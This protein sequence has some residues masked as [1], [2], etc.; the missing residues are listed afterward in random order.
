[1][2][3]KLTQCED[4]QQWDRFVDS[5]PQGNV[6]CSTPFLDALGEEYDLLLVEKDGHSQLG[7]VVLKRDGQPIPAP[8]SF[9]MYQGI[10]FDGSIRTMP[11][12][13][14]A[15]W[16]LE[17][18][19]FLLAEMEQRYNRISFCLH[20]ALEDLRSFQ[21]FHY[22]EPQR[23]QF[24]IELRYTGLVDLSGV[25]DFDTYLTAIRNLRRREYRRAQSKGLTVEESNDLDTLDRLH[26]LTFERQGID[27]NPKEERLLRA[28]SEAALSKSFGWLLLCK[29]KQGIAASATLFLY[30]SHCGYYL[31]G[32][33]DPDYRNSGSGTLLILENIRRCR[34]KGLKMVDFVGINS[35]NRG[36]FKTSFNA[37]PVPYFVVT[38]ERPSSGE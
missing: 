7:A 32:A 9:A 30:D 2:A 18:T 36:D 6:F 25:P 15:K 20:Y 14:R 1:M 34:E 38:W 4:K 29:D 24:K 5:S 16:S 13:S 27:R 31:L 11:R 22:H 23:G 8:Y 33:N 35:P 10:L 21:W 26:R 28:I 3:F 37:V 19:E 17:V 12:H